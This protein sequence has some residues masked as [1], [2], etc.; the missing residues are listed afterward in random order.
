MVN[1]FEK[2]DIENPIIIAH[3]F[4]AR[5][6][7]KGAKEIKYHKIILTGAAG[8]KPRRKLS[9][10]IKVYSYK[11]LKRLSR[12]IILRNILKK[13]VSSYSR[14]AGSVDYKNASPIMKGVLS[15]S[16]NEDLKKYFKYIKA[17]TLLIWGELDTATP[18]VNANV[19]EK[20][21]VDVGLV[22][23]DGCSNFAYIEQIS[24]FMTITDNFLGIK[25]K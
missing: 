10:Y 19:M 17:P 2:L 16:V 22:I 21:I 11:I 1:F 7:F 6:V 3:S 24:R 13:K 14:K 18:L 5:L 25:I 15:K 9:Y 12:I 4:G 8:I 20:M 23:F